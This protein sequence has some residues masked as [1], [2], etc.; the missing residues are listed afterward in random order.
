MSHIFQVGVGSGGMVV[1]DL[2]ARDERIRKVTLVDPDVY[3]PH[4]VQRHYFPEV[5][6]GESKVGLAARWIK[7]VRTHLEV[8]SLAYNVMDP[9]HQ[10]E[11]EAAVQA[12]DIGVCAVD[13]EPAKFHFDALMRM[14]NKPW[15]LGEVLSGGIGGWVHLFKPGGACYG[16]VASHLQRTVQTDASPTPD[17]AN[18]EAALAETRIPA[19]KA[20]ITAI[21]SLHANLTLDLLA[22]TD[23]GFTSMLLPLARVEGVFEEAYR[24][25]RFRIARSE[26]CLICGLTEKHLPAGEDLDVALD[27]ALSRL[28]NE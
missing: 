26:E 9:K 27:Q 23:P 8:V 1:L 28:G 21:A 18:P 6:S 15:A 4:N 14:F 12:C 3:K 13:V 5:N 25:Y 7:Q 2:L 24:P 11:I 10:E 20:S 16:C 19:S 17:Y 22:G